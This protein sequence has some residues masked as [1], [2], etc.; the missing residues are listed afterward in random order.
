MAVIIR[1]NLGVHRDE[2]LTEAWPTRSV[3]DPSRFDAGKL[4]MARGND[5]PTQPTPR[6]ERSDARCEGHWDIQF[7]ELIGPM[8]G[9]LHRLARKIL[10]SEDL[11]EDAVQ[12]A[13][14][15]LWKEGR[16][17]PNPA[18]WLSRTVIHRSL[19]L[20]RGRR[21]R[22]RHERQ[23]CLH[24]PEF[25][26][27]SEPLHAA[28]ADE[29]SASINQALSGLSERLRTVFVLR[30]IEQLDYESIAAALQIPLGTVRSRLARS[31]EALQQALRH[32]DR[33]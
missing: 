24:R 2:T 23:A 18:A 27:G 10:R 11:A 12:E 20:N 7:A 32:G 13:I 8:L 28:Q 19:H 5:N 15:S 30:E 6:H 22:D 33:T 31:R 4:R 26:P 16:L 9:R 17:P 29:I 21:R 3:R 14:V 25:D 1:E